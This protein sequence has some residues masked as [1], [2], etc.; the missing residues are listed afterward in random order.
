MR[1]LGLI[2]AALIVGGAA[3]ATA[4]QSRFWYYCDSSRAYYPYVQSCMT[5]WRRVAA[6]SMR[7]QNPTISNSDAT[8][9]RFPGNTDPPA[10]N[11]H[12]YIC[13]TTPGGAGYYPF[14]QRCS[15]QWRQVAARG[16]LP[17]RPP[18]PG[19]VAME[20]PAVQKMNW[21]DHLAEIA[22][23]YQARNAAAEQAVQNQKAQE[24]ISAQ[25]AKQRDADEK[26][27]YRYMSVSDFD[28]DK[29]TFRDGQKLIIR[30]VFQSFSDVDW[31]VAIPNSESGPKIG[32]LSDEAPRDVRAVLQ[33]CRIGGICGITIVGHIVGC[34]HTFLGSGYK[35]DRCLSVDGIKS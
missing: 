2:V 12:W 27:G 22:A 4:Q 5:P 3:P 23:E 30:G 20:T 24:I 14:V 9:A 10:G 13:D 11:D 16:P 7:L 32:L 34:E 17:P 31:L 6:K 21:D 25:A 26:N 19:W 28:L 18:M 1:Y 29:A 8:T 35:T 33:R 15:D